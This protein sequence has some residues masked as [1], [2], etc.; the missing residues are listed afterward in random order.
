MSVKCAMLDYSSG[1]GLGI[2][3]NVRLV[4]MDGALNT[5]AIVSFDMLSLLGLYGF[6]FDDLVFF[7]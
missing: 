7:W 1:L 5:Y 6:W 4:V 3:L 2:P